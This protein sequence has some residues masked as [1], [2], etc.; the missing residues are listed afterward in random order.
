ML[1]DQNGNKKGLVSID[2]AIDSAKKVS[3]DLVQVSR[4][5][6]KPIVCKIFDYG[7]YVFEKKK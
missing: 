2:K 3:L 4:S 1:I 7:K 5:D 6:A